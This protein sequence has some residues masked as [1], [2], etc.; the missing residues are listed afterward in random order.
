MVERGGRRCKAE[1]TTAAHRGVL[2]LWALAFIAIS[3]CSAGQEE[4]TLKCPSSLGSQVLGDRLGCNRWENHDRHAVLAQKKLRYRPAPV[5][6]SWT[7]PSR[8]LKFFHN[9]RN[10]VPQKAYVIGGSIST[11]VHPRQ[12]KYPRVIEDWFKCNYPSVA[13]ENAAVAGTTS[14]FANLCFPKKVGNDA[15]LVIVEFAANNYLGRDSTSIS[16]ALKEGVAVSAELHREFEQLIR[17]I[18]SLPNEPAVLLMHS[19]SPNYVDMHNFWDTPEEVLQLIGRYYSVPSI[20]LRDALYFLVKSNETLYQP[21]DWI[22][23]LVLHPN[24]LGHAYFTDLIMCVF[25]WA[26]SHSADYTPSPPFELPEPMFP[27]NYEHHSTCYFGDELKSIAIQSDGWLWLESW[28]PGFSTEETK[29]LLL[30]INESL[31]QNYTIGVGYLKSYEKVGKAILS[32]RGGCQCSPVEVDFLHKFH[33]SQQF[34]TL[35]SVTHTEDGNCIISV[36]PLECPDRGA[37][38]TKILTLVLDTQT[39][40]TLPSG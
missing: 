29:E 2:M 21:V 6:S 25:D 34:F 17:K 9:A 12:K 3:V 11:V 33:H 31:G 8:L 28:K 23:D 10:G 30:E 16:C 32:C 14:S 26:I 36:L 40:Q 20:S 38:Q 5:L 22:D 19:W 39:P 13:L 27:N 15:N 24:Y 37:V 7:E 35:M 4:S 1:S 18:L